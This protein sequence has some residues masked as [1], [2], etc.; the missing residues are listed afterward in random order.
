MSS[1]GEFWDSL[2]LKYKKRKE[3]KSLFFSFN[4]DFQ[5]FFPFCASSRHLGLKHWAFT[6]VS[7]S[8]NSIFRFG[9]LVFA[10]RFVVGNTWRRGREEFAH[11][12]VLRFLAPW[13]KIMTPGQMCGSMRTGE[14]GSGCRWEPLG[15]GGLLV[16]DLL[17]DPSFS[18]SVRGAIVAVGSRCFVLLFLHFHPLCLRLVLQFSVLPFSGEGS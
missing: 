16:A 13:S 4:V 15:A 5:I 3:K 18:R 14:Q 8:L 7:N 11:S 12:V 10:S 6:V 9:L 2:L 17:T 1:L